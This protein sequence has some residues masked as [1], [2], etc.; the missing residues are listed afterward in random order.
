M[1]QFV[2][3]WQKVHSKW[4]GAVWHLIGDFIWMLLFGSVEPFVMPWRLILVQMPIFPWAKLNKFLCGATTN[5]LLELDHWWNRALEASKLVKYSYWG[6]PRK[7]RQGPHHLKY[8]TPDEL[9]TWAQC[10]T[11]NMWYSCYIAESY[12]YFDKM[13]F[14]ERDT[15]Y[16]LSLQYVWKR[17]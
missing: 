16:S 14:I 15:K 9:S 5:R 4:N 17:R 6:H 2:A 1:K 11:Q 8:K 12:W 10:F 7:P 13:F 3:L